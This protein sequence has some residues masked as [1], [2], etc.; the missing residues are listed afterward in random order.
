MRERESL[1]CLYYRLARSHRLCPLNLTTHFVSLAPFA[2]L[3]SCNLL[4]FFSLS[5]Y[6]TPSFIARACLCPSVRVETPTA[7]P[8]FLSS[9]SLLHSCCISSISR[10]HAPLALFRARM[11]TLLGVVMFLFQPSS[12]IPKHLIYHL[13]YLIHHFLQNKRNPLDRTSDV[14]Y[15][16]D[17]LKARPTLLPLEEHLSHISLNRH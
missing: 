5:L 4:H 14:E 3:Q 16:I 7:A 2:L 1:S 6:I 15:Q 10:T 8:L 13:K 17:A 9:P 11:P 12:P